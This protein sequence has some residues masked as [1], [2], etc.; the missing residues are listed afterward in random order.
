MSEM[1]GNA[2]DDLFP[3]FT[4]FETWRMS[5]ELGSLRHFSKIGIFSKTFHAEFQFVFSFYSIFFL[6]FSYKNCF[7]ITI[8]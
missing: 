1:K 6:L 5:L 3:T 7:D 8:C 4:L 2:F